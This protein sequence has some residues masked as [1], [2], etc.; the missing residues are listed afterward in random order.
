MPLTACSLANK[1]LAETEELLGLLSSLRFAIG[2]DDRN[3]WSAMAMTV[4]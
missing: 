1:Q 4:A 2:V 3:D